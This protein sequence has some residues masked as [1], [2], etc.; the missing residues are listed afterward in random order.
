MN[1]ALS[2]RVDNSADPLE[3]RASVRLFFV[4]LGRQEL[5]KHMS[6]LALLYSRISIELQRLYLRWPGEVL[7][8]SG[9]WGLW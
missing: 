1:R 4:I 7:L 6:R 3:E 8:I 9:I 5:A 2:T